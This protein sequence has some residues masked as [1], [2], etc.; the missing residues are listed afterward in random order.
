MDDPSVWGCAGRCN[1]PTHCWRIFCRGQ[2][3]SSRILR[4]SVLVGLH[5]H[6]SWG[7][8]VDPSFAQPHRRGGNFGAGCCSSTSFAISTENRV[9]QR[10]AKRNSVF[11]ERGAIARFTATHPPNFRCTDFKNLLFEAPPV[12]RHSAAV[13]DSLS[14][15]PAV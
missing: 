6:T 9:I 10:I 11:L 5:A 15:P 8:S 1:Y 4:N 14:R 2:P 7:G 13:D 12:K 3:S